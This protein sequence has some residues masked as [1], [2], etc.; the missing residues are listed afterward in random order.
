M[1]GSFEDIYEAIS[2]QLSPNSPSESVFE[3]IER[4]RFLSRRVITKY[5]PVRVGWDFCS[6]VLNWGDKH[7]EHAERYRLMESLKHF[8][9][10]NQEQYEALYEE[11]FTNHI[12]H[13]LI[14]SCDINPLSNFFEYQLNEA[15]EKTCFCALTDSMD[16]SGFCKT[17]HLGHD[18]KPI[19][20]KDWDTS[21]KCLSFIYSHAYTRLVI[22]E[23]FVGSGEQSIESMKILEEVFTKV[24]NI[25]ALFVPLV[26]C[27]QSTKRVSAFLNEYNFSGIEVCSVYELPWEYILDP[28]RADNINPPNA[29][30]DD[31]RSSAFGYESRVKGSVGLN[32]PGAL[33][34]K[35][36]GALFAK[37]T[38]CPDNTLPLYNY[39]DPNSEWQP[40]FPRVP[41][42]EKAGVL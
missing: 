42:N 27:P 14:V 41:R 18:D 5:S 4:I 19:I 8:T 21:E 39:H 1:I 9:F 15:I 3:T 20:R 7:L 33:G 10:I 37:Y 32:Y 30:L 26:S 2:T 36:T 34:F 17:N 40:L 31:L 22:L 12:L 29:L 13:W 24:T 16:I 11:V 35:N 38:N 23:D 6:Q 25:K 28:E